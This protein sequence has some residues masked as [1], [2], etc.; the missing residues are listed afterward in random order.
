MISA[1]VWE[2][3]SINKSPF[4]VVVISTYLKLSDETCIILLRNWVCINELFI[5]QLL[6][7][8]CEEITPSKTTIWL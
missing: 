8:I 5:L 3:V 1:A 6:A 7:S 4:K 2:D